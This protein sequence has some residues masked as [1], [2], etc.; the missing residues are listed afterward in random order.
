MPK[1]TA[2]NAVF[3]KK[4]WEGLAT[5][6]T[7]PLHYEVPGLVPDASC[8]LAIHRETRKSLLEV[9]PTYLSPALL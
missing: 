8:C 2:L 6:P 4:I 5:L 7:H 3:R 1:F 9:A